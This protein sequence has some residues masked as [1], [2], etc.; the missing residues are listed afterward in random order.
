MLVL[1][2]GTDPTTLL[3]LR[4]KNILIAKQRIRLLGVH[5][6]FWHLVSALHSKIIFATFR[7]AASHKRMMLGE[8]TA[9]ETYFMMSAFPLEATQPSA[10][11]RV[12]LFHAYWKKIKRHAK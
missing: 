7:P 1:G 6:I 5:A 3:M 2:T 12:A 10:Y 4:M 8:L 9:L 11:V